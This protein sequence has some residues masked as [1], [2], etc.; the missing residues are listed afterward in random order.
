MSQIIFPHS[1]PTSF[2]E[3]R[4]LHL[5]YIAAYRFMWESEGA[6][7]ARYREFEVENLFGSILSLGEVDSF[8]DTKLASQLISAVEGGPIT[9]TSTEIRRCGFNPWKI[10][11]RRLAVTDNG[12]AGLV[13]DVTVAG[14][15]V[16]ILDGVATPF[17]LRKC[18]TLDKEDSG[19]VDGIEAYQL[20]GDAYIEGIMHGEALEG[21][22]VEWKDIYIV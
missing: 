6:L 12:Y 3:Q 11:R 13:P 15:V 17:L 8:L 16:V 10:S 9:V 14:D 1:K 7:K 21:D 2:G 18:P 22:D 20:V 19:F 4:T 5:E